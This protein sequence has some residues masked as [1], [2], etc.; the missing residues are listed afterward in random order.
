MENF[1]KAIDEQLKKKRAAMGPTEDTPSVVAEKTAEDTYAKKVSMGLQHCST[2]IDVDNAEWNREYASKMEKNLDRFKE[3]GLYEQLQ[4]MG[5]VYD[6][7]Q[8]KRSYAV[9]K[10]TDGRQN[11]V[12]NSNDPSYEDIEK[13]FD[14]I[15][16]KLDENYKNRTK[17]DN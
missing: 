5:I 11:Q 6:P 17:K 14:E 7:A 12:L 9:M 1:S 8:F 16:E 4:K 2:T 13:K 3:L 15:D 10:G